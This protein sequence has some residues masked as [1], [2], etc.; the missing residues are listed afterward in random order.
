MYT[1]RTT[2]C[3]H[4]A[5]GRAV[6]VPS[7]MIFYNLP[8]LDGSLIDGT[9][10]PVRW[11]AIAALGIPSA[12]AIAFLLARVAGQNDV[13]RISLRLL[14]FALG[15]EVLLLV[16]LAL[17]GFLYERRAQARDLKLHHPPGRLVDIGG[18]R[19]HISCTGSGPT[20]ILEYGH[21]ATYFDWS[22]VQPEIA[23]FAR[24]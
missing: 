12:L 1:K 24:V 18:Y 7:F 14:R 10:H 13:A 17:T 8:L 5:V 9:L 15:T 22:L 2:V 4:F 23:K 19:L 20:V 11:A 16:I 6:A 21:Q 3:V